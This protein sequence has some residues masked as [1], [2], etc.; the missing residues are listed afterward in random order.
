M[1]GRL[2]ASALVAFLFAVHPL[3]AEAVAWGGERKSA[4]SGL[5]FVSTIGAYVAYARRPFSI[6]RYLAVAGLFTLGLLSKPTVITL[7][8][9]L[10]VLDYWPLKRWGPAAPTRLSPTGRVSLSRLVIEKVP[11][12]LL[13][14]GAAVAAVLSQGENIASLEKLSILARIANA[15]NSYVVYI[16]QFFWPFGLAAFYPHS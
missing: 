3:R 5:F 10:L 9:L 11:L 4:L 6:I 13:S 15:L 7:P 8:F 14:A 16:G 12:V 2:W 1:T